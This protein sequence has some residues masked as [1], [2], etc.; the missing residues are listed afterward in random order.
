MSKPLLT[1]K[2]T[3]AH[4]TFAENYLDEPPKMIPWTND[5]TY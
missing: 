1:P 5:T 2:N 4:H 3:K